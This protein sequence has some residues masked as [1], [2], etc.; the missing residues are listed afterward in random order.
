ME[1][2]GKQ[3]EDLYS[4]TT[5]KVRR[6]VHASRLKLKLTQPDITVLQRRGFDAQTQEEL[7]SNSYKKDRIKTSN[8][9][10]S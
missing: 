1:G 8:A 9:R 5:P 2:N 7:I 3:S 6:L 10:F 4:E